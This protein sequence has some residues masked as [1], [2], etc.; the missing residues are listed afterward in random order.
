MAQCWAWIATTGFG[1][2]DAVRRAES[3]LARCRSTG[4]CSP[5]CVHVP[6]KRSRDAVTASEEPR[7]SESD[8]DRRHD[9]LQ[10]C[11]RALSGEAQAR[12]DVFARLEIVPRALCVLNRRLGGTLSPHDLADLAQQ[13]FLL[14]WSGLH[15]YDGRVP[16]EAWAYGVA[17]IELLSTLRRRRG[18]P[19]PVAPETL[20][21]EPERLVTCEIDPERVRAMLARLEPID[22]R[23][24]HM[25]HFEELDFESIARALGL[26]TVNA[27]SRHS[28][29]LERLRSLYGDG[30]QEGRA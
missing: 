25:R 20:H 17:R 24:L 23:L 10:L 22:A 2:Q 27:R 9:D 1:R 18:T 16:L 7:L 5:P 3:G 19:M 21:E 14:A 15:R 26:S 28:R 11:S 6:S 4:R 12:D 29:A 8:A 13:V 30:E